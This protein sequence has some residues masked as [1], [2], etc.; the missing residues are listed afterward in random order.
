MTRNPND[1]PRG[2]PGDLPVKVRPL[3]RRR[4]SSVQIAANL[5]E[6]PPDF[7]PARRPTRG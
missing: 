3:V 4:H 2:Y 7:A 5:G 1:G 6:A